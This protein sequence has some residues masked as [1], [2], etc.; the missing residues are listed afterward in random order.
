LLDWWNAARHYSGK[1]V[2]GVVSSVITIDVDSI[3]DALKQIESEGGS[4]L[5]PRTPIPGMGAFA[6]FQNPECNI[7]GLRRDHSL[8]SQ[9]RG[10]PL[11]VLVVVRG[12]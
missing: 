7:M 9:T 4:T 11:A 2:V 6:Y 12:S 5:T 8:G 1:A 10:A 3:D